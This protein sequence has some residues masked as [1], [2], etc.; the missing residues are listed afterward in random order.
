[1]SLL[2]RELPKIILLMIMLMYYL[3]MYAFG[4]SI[5]FPAVTWLDMPPGGAYVTN[6]K[7]IIVNNEGGFR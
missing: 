3:Y 4:Q 6:Q 5:S 7:E 1:M 2:Q